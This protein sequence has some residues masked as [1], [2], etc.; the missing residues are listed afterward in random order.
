MIKAEAS[1]QGNRTPPK[2]SEAA[3]FRAF[4]NNTSERIITWVI[5]VRVAEV[6]AKEVAMR[7]RLTDLAVA[8]MKDQGEVWD[9]LLPS[10]GIRV[11]ART[12]TWIIA[13]RRPGARHPVRLRVGA[14]PD[15]GVTEARAKARE[16][17]AGG[18]PPAPATFRTLAEEFL[19]HGRS[20]KGREW[21]PATLQAYRSALMLAAEPLHGRHVQDI[22]RRDIADLLRVVAAERGATMA[23]LTRAT[24]GRLWSWLVEVDRVDYSPVV[25][26]PVYEIG[27]RDR[28]LSDSELRAIW[29]A[30]E[31]PVDYHLIIRLLLWTGARRGEVGGMRWSELDNGVWTIPSSRAKNHRELVLPLPRQA[32]DVLDSRPR[33]VGRELLFGHGPR[34]FAGW[35]SAKSA[36]DERLRFNRPWTLHD[37]RRTTETR[38]AELGIAKE[39]RSRLLN[40]DVGEIE[41][42]YQHHTFLQ[43]KRAA[44]QAWADE[45]AQLTW[46]IH[47]GPVGRG[48]WIPRG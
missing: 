39:I 2:P 11:G 18:A 40:H 42:R 6:V 14:Y 30:T 7:R 45:L 31:E 8:R 12:K 48:A 28:V 46:P 41:H 20:R 44:L 19:E 37:I 34:G 9:M 25:G 27:R 35:S 23:A 26:T 15:L 3:G 10:F 47:S 29:T 1:T 13:T 24:L 22:R 17:M 33:L 43:E 5:V 21:R 36:L 4:Q 16:M 38:L 32:Q